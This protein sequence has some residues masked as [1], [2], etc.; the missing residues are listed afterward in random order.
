MVKMSKAKREELFRERLEYLACGAAGCDVI[1]ELE[2][3]GGD[4]RAEMINCM[5]AG[6]ISRFAVAVKDTMMPNSSESGL[7]WEYMF[8][9]HNFDK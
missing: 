8:K 1:I 3:Y 4:E 9:A 2:E 5:S 7:S 6:G